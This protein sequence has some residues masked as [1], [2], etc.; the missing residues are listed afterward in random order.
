MVATYLAE[1]GIELLQNQYDSLYVFCKKQPSDVLC[2]TSSSETPGQIAWRLFK[3]R[4]GSG[5]GQSCFLK[6]EDGSTDNSL[7]CSY[8]F[9]HMI[10]DITSNPTRY[11][12]SASQCSSIAEASTTLPGGSVRH[13]YVCTGEALHTAGASMSSKYF[14]RSVTL[15]WMPTFETNPSMLNHYQDDIR[16]TARVGYKGFNG[17]MYTTTI[18]RFMHSQ[19]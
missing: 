9:I 2:T 6:H 4:F 12:A 17:Y 13:S 7:G 11:L 3:D 16:I 15:E 19:P 5:G 8:D 1:E 10:G 14:T 18:T